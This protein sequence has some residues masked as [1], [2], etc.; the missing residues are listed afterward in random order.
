MEGKTE[1]GQTG[2][3]EEHSSQFAQLREL[4]ARELSLEFENHELRRSLRKSTSEV[5]LAREYELLSAD[6]QRLAQLVEQ[7][8]ME[9]EHLIESVVNL[10]NE[11]DEVQR[12]RFDDTLKFKQEMLRHSEED[13]ASRRVKYQLGLSIIELLKAKNVDTLILQEVQMHITNASFSTL[14]SQSSKAAGNDGGKRVPFAT[15]GDAN[16]GGGSGGDELGNSNHGGGQPYSGTSGRSRRRRNRSRHR[17]ERDEEGSDISSVSTHRTQNSAHT[18]ATSADR[19][20]S[21]GSP[22]SRSGRDRRRDRGSGTRP[23]DEANE[24]IRRLAL[25]GQDPPHAQEASGGCMQ[26]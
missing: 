15:N 17:L 1:R 9:K 22:R 11:V 26:A 25:G 5:A 3:L 10:S 16:A 2:E 8:K 21:R 19:H 18:G 12:T 14:P 24:A 6:R 4:K 13:K 7:L 23:V 20:S